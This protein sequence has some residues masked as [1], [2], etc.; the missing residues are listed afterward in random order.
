VETYPIKKVILLTGPYQS[1]KSRSMNLLSKRLQE[2]HQFVISFDAS[3]A[4]T[5]EELYGIIKSAITE[6]LSRTS[7][8]DSSLKSYQTN[9]EEE[10]YSQKQDSDRD[11]T[12]QLHRSIS[13]LLRQFS[14]SLKPNQLE[15][16][17]TNFFRI[18]SKATSLQPAIFIH[19]F[20]H[21][22]ELGSNLTPILA[23]NLFPFVE[24][25]SKPLFNLEQDFQLLLSSIIQ[26]TGLL[27][28]LSAMFA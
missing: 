13:T 4:K 1:G 14:L 6:G 22:L 11:L 15:S 12:A 7:F 9:S 28:H 17:V 27:I 3:Y 23:K 18:I 24:N 5:I 19:N 16:S 2:N 21:I 8:A 26:R 20:D 25:K 10:D